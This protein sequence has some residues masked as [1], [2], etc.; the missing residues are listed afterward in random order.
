MITYLTKIRLVELLFLRD[1]HGV[2]AYKVLRTHVWYRERGLTL[3][4]TDA[5]T[6]I[7]QV[8]TLHGLLLKLGV[9]EWRQLAASLARRVL[10]GV[11]EIESDE[12]TTLFEAGFGHT[13]AVGLANYGMSLGSH[14]D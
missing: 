12:V 2:E 3:H 10:K 5:L 13:G 4:D 7:M 6:D 1:L 11:I 8:Y 14:S 9:R